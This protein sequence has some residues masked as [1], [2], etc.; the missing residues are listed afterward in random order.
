MNKLHRIQLLTLTAGGRILRMEDE[1][2]GLSIERR[3]DPR[4]PLVV[5]KERLERLFEAML[6]SDLSVVGS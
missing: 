6:Q 5:Q 3:L 1:A 4:L 2:S